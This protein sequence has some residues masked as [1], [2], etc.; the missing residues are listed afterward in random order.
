MRAFLVGGALCATAQLVVDST[1]LNPAFV[2][3]TSVSVGA[4]LSGLGLYGALVELGGAGAS[5]PLFGFGH[6]LV[7]GMVED[8][9]KMGLFG[10]LTGGFRAVS[11]GLVAAL[12]FGYIM[13]VVFNPKG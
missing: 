13:A 10:I 9:Q 8:A 7:T 6:S 3:V 11:A 12:I 2:M 5:I 1:K 4:L